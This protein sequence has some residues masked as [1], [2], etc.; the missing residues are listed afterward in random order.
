MQ[1]VA[2]G[3]T[4]RVLEDLANAPVT[5]VGKSLNLE[6]KVV[7]KFVFHPANYAGEIDTLT[8]RISYADAVGNPK[9]VDLTEVEVYSQAKSYYAFTLDTLLAAE[10]RAVISAQIYAGDTPVSA[11]LQYSPDT[12]GN[13]KTGNLLNLCKALFAYSDSAKA[14]FVS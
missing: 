12:Y 1:A 5:W 11:T 7:L 9:T 13:N 8:L 6:S 14:Y 3:N 2:F 10:L 4:N